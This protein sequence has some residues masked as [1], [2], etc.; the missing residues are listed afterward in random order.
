MPSS[1]NTLR[2]AEGRDVADVW[3]AWGG[4]V[5][6]VRRHYRPSDVEG[7][8]LEDASG[9]RLGL[10]TW[11]IDGRRA[12]IVTLDVDAQRHGYGSRLMEAAEERL[13]EVGTMEVWLLTSND[14]AD[15]LRF[16]LR[17]GY[18]LVR[19]HLDAFDEVRRAKPATPRTGKG[20]V[21]LRDLWELEKS[22][23]SAQS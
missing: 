17:H 11:C 3:K 10:V 6:S 18:R 19:V 5:V 9:R 23:Q 13:V 1:T 2:S 16:Y 15:A 8:V 12:E 7:L 14:N 21:P 22:L 20:G 4:L